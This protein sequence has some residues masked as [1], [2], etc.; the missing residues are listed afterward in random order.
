MLEL[1]TIYNCDCM[2]PDGIQALEEGSIDLIYCD[3]PFQMTQNTWDNIIPLE[4]MWK[5][6]RRVSKPNAPVV[7][8]AM[9]LFSAL[10]ISSNHKEYKYKWYWQK[11]RG[12]GHLNAKKMPMRNVEEV[13]V[14]YCK[15]PT[16]NPQMYEG[17]RCHS[18]GK[19]QGV[20][21]RDHSRNTNYGEFKK[22][23]TSGNLK[24]PKTLLYFPRDTPKLHPTQKPL[25]LAEYLIRT[26]TNSGDTVLDIT[27]GSGT[28]ML[29]AKNSGRQFL[30]FEKDE[31]HFEIAA[32]RI[33]NNLVDFWHM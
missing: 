3:L 33:S 20:S 10:L 30:G 12:T 26:Y 18:V 31:G 11:D 14:F 15:Q 29:A 17:E 23:N 28:S 22:V 24:Y 9:E 13:L 21:Q 6:F 19:A 7:L 27:V 16:Y 5:E 8:H 2:A 25:A 4:W 1:D 32:S